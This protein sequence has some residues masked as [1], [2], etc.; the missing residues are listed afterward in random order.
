MWYTILP[1]DGRNGER[2]GDGCRTGC[3][4]AVSIPGPE[5]VS[6]LAGSPSN[7]YIWIVR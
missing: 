6:A 2:A 3:R 1:F 5:A 7:I 4:L